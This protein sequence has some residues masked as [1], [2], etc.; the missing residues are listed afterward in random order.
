MR[1]DDWL[2]APYQEMYDDEELYEWADAAGI[3]VTGMDAWD[4]RKILEAEYGPDG[5]D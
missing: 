5:D 1:Y 3:D 4:I 2:E